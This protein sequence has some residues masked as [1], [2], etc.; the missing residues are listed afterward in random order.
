MRF[1]EVGSE[2]VG[3]D[4]KVAGRI[5]ADREAEL[6]EDLHVVAHVEVTGFS[7]RA[8]DEDNT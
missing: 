3:L 8:G 2:V 7:A 1:L 5:H 6:G 4:G